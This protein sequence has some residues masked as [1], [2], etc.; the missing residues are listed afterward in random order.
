MNLI[1][2]RDKQQPR[3]TECTLGVLTVGDLTFQTMERP[4]VPDPKGPC[5]MH[6]VSCI[7]PGTYKLTPRFTQRK[8]KH[9]LLSNP[10]L[11]LYAD[12]SLIPDGKYGRSLVLIHS[13][14]WA[15][16]LNGCIAPGRKRVLD[17]MGNW[18]VALSVDSMDALR[19]LLDGKTDL[20]ITIV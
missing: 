7:C 3:P 13:A 4:W 19:K 5:G 6:D 15:N 2:T 18:I 11:G 16:E 17:T 8:G 14:N 1:L 10:A 20:S 12:P 9:W